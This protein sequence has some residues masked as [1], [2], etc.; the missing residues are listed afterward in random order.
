MWVA[1]EKEA[2][3]VFRYKFSTW[4]FLLF[5]VIEDNE[6]S[7]EKMKLKQNIEGMFVFI[8]IPTTDSWKKAHQSHTLQL[9]CF[10]S[11]ITF[12]LFA[13]CSYFPVIP[14]VLLPIVLIIL[15]MYALERWEEI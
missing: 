13:P 7:D 10:L 3:A 4:H 8:L 6:I 15:P 9:I 1:E 14:K 11:L 12:V 2:P 5:Q